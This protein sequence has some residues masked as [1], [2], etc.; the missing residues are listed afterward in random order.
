[1]AKALCIIDQCDLAGIEP[2]DHSLSQA[3]DQCLGAIH[4][5]FEKTIFFGKKAEATGGFYKARCALRD[6]RVSTAE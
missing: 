2:I 5:V 6:T 1:M 3:F 4:E